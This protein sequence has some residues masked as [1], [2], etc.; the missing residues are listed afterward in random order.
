MSFDN[1]PGP[2]VMKFLSCTTQLIMKFIMLINI[3]M[4]TI[5]D[6]FIFISLI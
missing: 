1:N 6:I 3:K 5:V 2:D 4:Q